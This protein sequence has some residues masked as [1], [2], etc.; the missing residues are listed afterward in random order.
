[1]KSFV[2]IT[3]GGILLAIPAMSMASA[4][5]FDGAA[6]QNTEL[7]DPHAGTGNISAPIYF[8]SYDCRITSQHV[9]VT[10]NVPKIT[11]PPVLPPPAILPPVITPPHTPPGNN[12]PPPTTDGPT[13]DNDPTPPVNTP[14]LPP[15]AA[16][17]LPASSEMA[18]V[19]LAFTSMLSWARSR[20][21]ARR[22]A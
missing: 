12:N 1:M 10:V 8:R 14:D 4:I 16:V 6:S 18:G 5:T 20:R 13:T 15:P 11:V 9:T 19:G 7:F 3:V 2:R 17:P 21:L 22:R